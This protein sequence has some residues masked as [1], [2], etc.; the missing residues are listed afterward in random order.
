MKN[1]TYSQALL[2]QRKFKLKI[3]SVYKVKRLGLHI[4]GMLDFDY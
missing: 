1:V 2:L 3:S 4:A